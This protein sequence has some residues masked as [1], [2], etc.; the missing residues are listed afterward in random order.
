MT[1]AVVAAKMNGS[2]SAGLVN[3]RP[4]SRSHPRDQSHRSLRT[5]AMSFLDVFSVVGFLTMFVLPS[6]ARPRTPWSNVL[7]SPRRRLN[8]AICHALDVAG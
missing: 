7:R 8:A 4:S 1:C 5:A 3:F 2:S 6:I